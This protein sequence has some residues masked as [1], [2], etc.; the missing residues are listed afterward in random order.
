MGKPA[1]GRDR[2]DGGGAD[3]AT[4]GAAGNGPDEAADGAALLRLLATAPPEV[5]AWLA[6]QAA[7]TAEGEGSAEGAAE[8]PAV[9]PDDDADPTTHEDEDDDVLTRRATVSG[10]AAP[11]AP[12]RRGASLRLLLVVALAAGAVA[13][14]WF[15]GRPAP[16]PDAATPTLAAD[17]ADA[18]AEA[19]IAELE[20]RLAADPTDVAA[21]LELGVLLFNAERLEAAGEHWQTATRLAPDEAEAWYNLGFFH[22][23]VEP[24]DYAAA[25][26][27]WER[28]V[29]IDPDSELAR[30]AAMHLG[31]VLADGE[32]AGEGAADGDA[33][34]GDAS[35]DDTDPAPDDGGAG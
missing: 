28:V 24:P 14:V 5:R 9:R 20:A 3:A 12:A 19:R 17:V 30:V 29:A 16:D 27:C 23:S 33:P 2:E 11:G 25:R 15:A 13:G 4:G 18:E 10:E 1:E 7:G 21:H 32:D 35:P 8:P 34:E 6:E 31:G 26:E 22:A